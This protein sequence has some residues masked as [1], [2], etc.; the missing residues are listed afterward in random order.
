[1][2]IIFGTFIGVGGTALLQIS[3]SLIYLHDVEVKPR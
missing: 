2:S 3:V 1:M